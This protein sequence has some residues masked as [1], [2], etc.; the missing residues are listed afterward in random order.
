V[1]LVH[2]R[3]DDAHFGFALHLTGI[4]VDGLDTVIS[5]APIAD[6]G[7]HT[8]G[9][10][11]GF[12]WLKGTAN[13]EM[14][15]WIDAES[16]LLENEQ[17]ELSIELINT[18]VGISLCAGIES[19]AGWDI[20][21]G[22]AM[23]D[24]MGCFFET[25]R[26]VNFTRTMATIDNMRV[27]SATGFVNAELNAFLFDSFA[28]LVSIAGDQLLQA[29]PGMLQN[30]GPELLSQ[31]VWQFIR[32]NT[33]CP[34]PLERPDEPYFDFR[35]DEFFQDIVELVRTDVVPKINTDFIHDYTL[36]SSGK[37]GTIKLESIPTSS[38]ELVIG[39]IGTFNTGADQVSVQNVDT[40]H[41][42]VFMDTPALY[43]L[44]NGF[45]L[46]GQIKFARLLA[47]NE[48]QQADGA[49]GEDDADTNS[50]EFPPVIFSSIVEF[51]FDGHEVKFANKFEF[52]LKLE[53]LDVGIDFLAKVD[54]FKFDSLTVEELLNFDC[55]LSR[56]AEAELLDADI[57][58]GRIE[59]YIRCIA[60]E[61]PAMTK[62]EELSRDPANQDNFTATVN[63]WI[64]TVFARFKTAISAE[65]LSA[66]IASSEA[67]CNGTFEERQYE[68]YSAPDISTVSVFG[69][70]GGVA[71]AMLFGLIVGCC[72]RITAPRLFRR[73][74]ESG[75]QVV[76]DADQPVATIRMRVQR[77]LSDPPD[78]AD[79]MLQSGSL[80]T[81]TGTDH[82]EELIESVKVAFSSS[83]LM[84][85]P[86]TPRPV[87]WCVLLVLFT[88]IWLFVVGHIII[89]ANVNINFL[90]LGE[91][92]PMHGFAGFS[93]G[94]SIKDLWD[95]GIIPL[96]LLLGTLS[97]AWPYIKVL[98]ML[99]CWVL[100]PRFLGQA[101]RGRILMT[102]DALGKWSMI[103]VYVLFLIMVAFGVR[104]ESPSATLL[105]ADLYGIH[106]VVDPDIG[107]ISFTLAAMLSLLVNNICVNCHRN[108]VTAD[109][110][111]ARQIAATRPP[112]FGGQ[113]SQS[114]SRSPRS[115]V[116][117]P[118][119]GQ[120]RGR[121]FSTWLG[122][123]TEDVSAKQRAVAELREALSGHVYQLA[124]GKSVRFS[125]VGRYSIHALLGI[126]FLLVV[127]G[128][129]IICFGFKIQGVVG[130]FIDVDGDDKSWKPLSMFDLFMFAVNQALASESGSF[131]YVAGVIFLATAFL[132]T[133]FVMPLVQLIGLAFLWQ[134]PLSLQHQKW[135]FFLAE[136]FG[137]W[138]CV[139]VFI[140]AIIIAVLEMGTIS[141]AMLAG[142]CSNVIDTINW[143]A[144]VGIV[145]DENRTCLFVGS[146]L[147]YGT[148]LLLSAAVL[149]NAVAQI[150]L[151]SGHYAI[152]EREAFVTSAGKE[153]ESEAHKHRAG[154]WFFRAC[155]WT[156]FQ[157]RWLQ[158]ADDAEHLRRPES[159]LAAS[160]LQLASTLQ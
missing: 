64:D 143:M 153:V 2:V 75:Q 93:I 160:Q 55:L 134:R 14:S 56:L 146:S 88:N 141:S 76:H 142:V 33:A 89:C 126:A 63:G 48:A 31:A 116:N 136:I 106:V 34:P 17:F 95:S 90:V 120:Q 7:M 26:Y 42:V 94:K 103:D 83:P 21:F 139:D 43:V 151:R 140:V 102:L 155:L 16:K 148:A 8:L 92:I 71:F 145:Q 70:M 40:F 152:D 109:E 39:P 158:D 29:L 36:E 124:S 25:V 150:I 115:A 99:T 44:R 147:E 135:W 108:A 35:S 133:A 6:D 154:N 122:A 12:G 105:P 72:L 132:I 87:R 156:A 59:L 114:A 41:D 68:R 3:S 96:C 111:L 46:G 11:M 130:M 28:G 24:P 15:A 149:T 119:D 58:I 5:V 27:Q 19:Q 13:F 127:V 97:G 45:K 81:I 104:I 77:L 79:I 144:N 66:T 159:R 69:V 80:D 23:Q 107:L 1:E 18:F 85:H 78:A 9:V 100:P 22:S 38:G 60:C 73:K 84:F 138:A 50:T 74:R 20:Q 52:T 10:D 51:N 157:L 110:Q 131:G 49:A 118:V 4:E 101:K 67:K 47:E 121:K 129:S 123:G 117:D 137:A 98:S 82:D 91:D 30:A 113:G 54:R 62:M 37:A 53:K 61:S 32:N 112:R 86:V 57:N 128:S 125:R 65:A